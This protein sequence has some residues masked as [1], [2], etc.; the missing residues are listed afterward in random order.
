VKDR[1]SVF[2]FNTSA[3]PITGAD[4]LRLR[5]N[6]HYGFLWKLRKPEHMQLEIIRADG[7]HDISSFVAE[8][9]VSTDVWFYPWQQEG[10]ANYFASNEAQ[11]RI[12][13][14]PPIERI[15]L[16]ISPF[17]WV[18]QQPTS[19]TIESADAVGFDLK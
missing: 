17:D 13:R 9:K 8:P 19:V 15:R 12:G 6:V 3:W 5:I 7:S 2:E 1:D 16:L 14:R 10:L 18:S 11:W 4:F